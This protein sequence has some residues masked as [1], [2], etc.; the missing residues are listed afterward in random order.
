MFHR[1]FAR[2]SYIALT[3]LS[4]RTFTLGHDITKL[5][6]SI[7]KQKIETLKAALT[8]VTHQVD[9]LVKRG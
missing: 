6:E 9:E 8:Q 2:H 7:D 1:T 4:S 5:S 3:F